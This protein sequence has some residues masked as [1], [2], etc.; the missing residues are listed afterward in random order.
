V[1]AEAGGGEAGGGEAGPPGGSAA[2]RRGAAR[3]GL[4][5]LGALGLLGLWPGAARGQ[6]NAV[7]GARTDW[8]RGLVIATGIGVADRHAP[9]AVAARGPARRAA[10][11]AARKQLAAALPALPLAEGGTLGSRLADARV[12]AGLDRAV[13]AAITLDADPSTDGSWKV[14]LAVPVEA[15]RQAIAG[16]RALPATASDADTPPVVI[17]EGVRAAPAIGYKLGPIAA[18]TLWVKDVPAWAKDAPRVKARGARGG[19]IDLADVRG[20]ESTLFVIVSG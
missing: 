18:P 14:T 9:S 2:D 6:G 10:E 7:G 4:I 11:E 20:S 15:L 17:V 1:T 13:A 5:A 12:Q 3:G 8:A 19:A 16:P